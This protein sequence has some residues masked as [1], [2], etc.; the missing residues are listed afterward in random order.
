[1]NIS[2]KVRP[3][4]RS[5]ESETKDFWQQETGSEYKMFAINCIKFIFSHLCEPTM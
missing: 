2:L 3:D 4:N 5:A 1:M